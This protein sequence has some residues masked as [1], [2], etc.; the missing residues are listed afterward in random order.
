MKGG[1]DEYD[2]F[3]KE[4][5]DRGHMDSRERA[6]ETVRATL[7]TLAERLAGGEPHDLTSQLPPGLAEHVRYD[8]EQK[9]EPFSLQEFFQ[10]VAEKE[11]T[12]APNAVHQAQVVMEVL[13]DAVTRGEIDNVKSQLPREYAPLFEAGN[14]VEMD[15]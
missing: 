9:S 3:I 13:Q 7:R 1:E 11:G 6:E 4:V 8:E 10:R 14:Q 2:E 12:E 15:I 5:Q